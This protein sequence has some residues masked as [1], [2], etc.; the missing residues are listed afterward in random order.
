ACSAPRSPVRLTVRYLRR[1]ASLS[2]ERS[3]CRSAKASRSFVTMSTAPEQRLKELRDAIR[4]HEERYY[5]HNEPEISDEQ[6]DTLLHELERLEAEHP[7][8][9]TTDSPTQPVAGRP[10]QG[11]PAVEH[12]ARMLSRDKGYKEDELRGFDGRV[13]RG[14]RAGAGPKGPAVRAAGG[15]GPAPHAADVASDSAGV[16]RVVSDPPGVAYV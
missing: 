5:I 6:F 11:F 4:H 7:D 8:L 12:L 10:I 1:S 14:L 13:R 15:K 9:L 2:G 16:E 3:S